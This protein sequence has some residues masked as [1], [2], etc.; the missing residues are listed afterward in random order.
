MEGEAEAAQAA[1]V[2][3]ERTSGG[4][5]YGEPQG[6]HV[7]YADSHD[8]EPVATADPAHL[9][10]HAAHHA[11]ETLQAPHASPVAEAAVAEP[12]VDTAHAVAAVDEPVTAV[13]HTPATVAEAAAPAAAP[14]A[15]THVP[16]TQAS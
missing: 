14:V 8:A 13:E 4:G 15:S 2:A 5:G 6:E 11:T 12:V 1:P 10:G 16:P 3:V 9:N 7:E